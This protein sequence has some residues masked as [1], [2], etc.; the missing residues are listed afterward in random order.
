MRGHCSSSNFPSV[1]LCLAGFVVRLS[2]MSRAGRTAPIRSR[3]ISRTAWPALKVFFF[4]F[5]LR[6]IGA[7]SH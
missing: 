3:A 1:G 4:F 5:V 6:G 2:G 7:S